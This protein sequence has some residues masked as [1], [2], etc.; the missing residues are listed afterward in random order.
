VEEDVQDNSSDYVEGYWFGQHA[1]PSQTE[2]RDKGEA[3][4]QAGE[5]SDNV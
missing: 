2:E 4:N 3:Q 5:R 1:Q